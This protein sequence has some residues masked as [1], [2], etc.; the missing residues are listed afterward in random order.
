MTRS[1]LRF[2]MQAFLVAEFPVVLR[3][4]R[5]A[6]AGAAHLAA[7]YATAAVRELRNVKNGSKR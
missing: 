3:G 2:W 5:T 6:P 7:E 1:E 4:K